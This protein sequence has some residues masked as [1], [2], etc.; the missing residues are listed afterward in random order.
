MYRK[1]GFVC[2]HSLSVPITRMLAFVTASGRSSQ[3]GDK[4]AAL[5]TC[6]HASL[7]SSVLVSLLVRLLVLTLHLLELLAAL[8]E[9][10]TVATRHGGA[11]AGLFGQ[12]LGVSWVLGFHVGGANGLV[13]AAVGRGGIDGLSGCLVLI[14]IFGCYGGEYWSVH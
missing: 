13:T 9:T 12:L 14:V 2:K 8:L 5:W 6:P 3:H 11:R 1:V 7:S 4:W 10:L